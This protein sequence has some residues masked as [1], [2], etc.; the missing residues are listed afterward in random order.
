[1]FWTEGGPSKITM[2]LSTG[3][4][5]IESQLPAQSRQGSSSEFWA[6]SGSNSQGMGE[7]QWAFMDKFSFPPQS[8]DLLSSSIVCCVFL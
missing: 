2:F 3:L 8:S 4:Q 1:M 7:G 6:S 5:S